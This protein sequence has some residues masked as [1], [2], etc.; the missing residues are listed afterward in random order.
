MRKLNSKKTRII[1][2]IMALV[3]VLILAAGITFSWMEGGDRGYVNGSEIVISTGSNLTMR[4]DGKTT[5]SIV[6]PT[7]VLDEVSSADG[8]NYY[9]PLKDNTTNVTNNMYFREGTAADENSKY[10]SLDFQLTAGDSATDVYLG[11]G[12]I[13]QC[14]NKNVMDALRMSFS[15][16]DG[17]T[18]VVFKPTQ[19][20]GVTMNYAPIT[21]ITEAGVPTTST[22]STSAYADYSYNGDGSTP[23]FKLAKGETLNITLSLWLEGT[24]FTSDDVANQ[25][26]SI[27]IDFTTTVDDLVKYTFV[28]NTHGYSTGKL[29]TWVSNTD[30]LNGNTYETMMYIY[31][32]ISSRYYV[33]KKTSDTTWSAYVPK[34]ITNFYFRRYSIDIDQW[35]NEWEPSMSTIPTF[36]NER[37]YVAICGNGAGSGTELDGCYGYWKDQYGTYRVYFQMECDWTDLHCYAWKSSGTPTTT[38]GAWPGTGMTFVKNVDNDPYKPLYYIEFNEAD[39]VAGIQFNNGN[40]ETTIYFGKNYGAS[41]HAYIH[42]D[43]GEIFGAWPGKQATYDTATGMYKVVLD[44]DTAG[45]NFYV[46]V[47]N[48]SGG[49]GNQ[50]PASGDGYLGTTG[51]AYDFYEGS[52]N[53]RDLKVDIDDLIP[54]GDNI[55]DYIFNGLSLWYKNSNSGGYGISTYMGSEGSLIY[56][57]N[58][59]TP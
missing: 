46:I 6:I 20:P 38:T 58:D 47:N 14:D 42:G 36:N 57:T 19:M 23:I 13:I 21:S 50:F 33:M 43:I 54:S 44:T 8:R 31:D 15:T 4:Q 16:N 34:T 53:T 18:P 56:P 2:S 51:N 35:W 40:T 12:T 37:T 7:C 45:K 52:F 28:D 3:E 5:N 48:G 26:L 30:S 24:V 11:A 59:P 55:E 39:D 29:E 49:E 17:S 1:L 32:N 41:T 10:L 27:Y 9:I 22:T 25:N